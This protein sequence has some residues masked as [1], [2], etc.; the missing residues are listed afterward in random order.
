M[1]F[2]DIKTYH[3]QMSRHREFRAGS[4]LELRWKN[5][6]DLSKEQINEHAQTLISIKKYCM[7]AENK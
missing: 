2:L 5:K 7:R 4:M 6:K 3:K 1:K